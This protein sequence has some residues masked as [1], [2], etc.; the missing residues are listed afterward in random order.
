[1]K[2]ITDYKEVLEAIGLGCQYK[3]TE[4]KNAIDNRV[5]FETKE[6]NGVTARLIF[7]DG[8]FKMF[9]NSNGQSSNNPAIVEKFRAM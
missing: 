8:I 1:M 5:T 2:N 4:M 6:V 7:V 3:V 9:D